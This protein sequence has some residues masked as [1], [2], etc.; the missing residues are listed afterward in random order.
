MFVFIIAY[1]I[2]MYMPIIG[3][4]T[5]WPYALIKCGKLPVITS[6]FMADYSYSVPGMTSYRGPTWL[7]NVNSYVCTPQDAVQQ[8][9][10][11]APW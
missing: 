2:S 3:G 5:G 8:G 9:Y 11:K 6:D 4:Y 7:N 1:A 10:R